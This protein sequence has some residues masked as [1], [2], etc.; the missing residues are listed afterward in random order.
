MSDRGL[1]T[2]HPRTC[3][4]AHCSARQARPID[5]MEMRKQKKIR[6]K[7]T[8][9]AIGHRLLERP[10]ARYGICTSFLSWQ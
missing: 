4:S 10:V 8:G 6:E 5:V 9:E 3:S 7:R 2:R 1:L